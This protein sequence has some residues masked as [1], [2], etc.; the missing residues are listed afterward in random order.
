MAGDGDR[1]RLPVFAVL[2]AGH[3]IDVDGRR[4]PTV[5]IDAH[6]APEVADLARVHAVEGVGD[7]RTEA[8]RS[9]D[10]VVLGVRVTVPVR[11]AFAIAIDLRRHREL[12]DD[13]IECGSLVIAH[14]DPGRAAAEQPTWLALDIDG[15]ALDAQIRDR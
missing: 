11:A 8:I 13:V 4:L 3:T 6:D 7:I 10:V 5:V 9:G 2:D 12:L 14:T 15:Q 1:L